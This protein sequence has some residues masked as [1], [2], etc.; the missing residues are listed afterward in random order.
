[1]GSGRPAVCGCLSEAS[2]GSER[3]GQGQA[4]LFGTCFGDRCSLPSLQWVRR[5]EPWTVIYPVQVLAL[6]LGGG[7]FG[8]PRV[9]QGWL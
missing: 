1:M 8:S 6:P 4:A 3:S 7:D 2:A 9:F 5:K